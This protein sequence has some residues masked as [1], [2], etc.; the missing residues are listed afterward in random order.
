MPRKDFSSLDRRA[1]KKSKIQYKKYAPLKQKQR[2]RKKNLT[3]TRIEQRKMKNLQK[4]GFAPIEYHFLNKSWEYLQF[5]YHHWRKWEKEIEPDWRELPCYQYAFQLGNPLI[6]QGFQFDP[7]PKRKKAVIY[8]EFREYLD[9][10][11]EDCAILHFNI[12]QFLPL[13]DLE[14]YSSRFFYDEYQ[15]AL[16]MAEYEVGFDIVGGAQG[17]SDIPIKVD[18]FIRKYKSNGYIWYVAIKDKQL[19]FL[20]QFAN[21]RCHDGMIEWFNKE[22]MQTFTGGTSFDY[23][24]LNA[25]N[26][27]K[28]LDTYMWVPSRSILFSNYRTAATLLRD[29]FLSDK[30]TKS[31][32][33]GLKEDMKQ[34]YAEEEDGYRPEQQIQSIIRRLKRDLRKQKIRLCSGNWA[35]WYEEELAQK[36][37]TIERNIETMQ[38]TAKSLEDKKNQK[39]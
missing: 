29:T 16:D 14:H 8:G 6:E 25:E 24:P 20:V 7:S 3:R 23:A 34:T 21:R 36:V 9:L 26:L 11:L 31:F 5:E 15:W 39:S 22:K 27:R 17:W 37:L 35:K 33:I 32:K 28:V 38:R 12:S 10:P 13:F 4:E 30:K 18:M 2:N 1:K 19:V